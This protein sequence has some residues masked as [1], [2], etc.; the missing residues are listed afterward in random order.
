MATTPRGTL[1]VGAEPVTAVD[2]VG[3]G[4]SFVA[5]YLAAL[6]SDVDDARRLR[7]A[8]RAAALS[9]SAQGDWEGLPS[10]DELDADLT[11]G[12]VAR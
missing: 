2:P 5:G 6:L 8:T 9:V 10:T 7:T 1:R 3:A 12:G 11:P 4:D